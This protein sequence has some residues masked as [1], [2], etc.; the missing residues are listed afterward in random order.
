MH[1]KKKQR[2]IAVF[3]NIYLKRLKNA[4]VFFSKISTYNS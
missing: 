1:A 4:F 2:K 3:F